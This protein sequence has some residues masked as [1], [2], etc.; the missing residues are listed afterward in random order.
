MS[1]L[2][3]R[4][5]GP[6][7]INAVQINQN[8]L[9]FCVPVLMGKGKVQQTVIWVDGFSAKKVDASGSKGFGG[10]LSNQY[11]YSADVLAA[12]CDGATGVVGIGDV[13]SGQSWLSNTN[14]SE[15]YTIGT[16]SPVY[17]PVNASSMT[18]DHG[19]AR[20]DSLSATYDDL[21]APVPTV[22]STSNV[23]PFQRVPYGTTL[24]TGEYS[25]DPAT[26]AYHF[27][28]S[29]HG[30][31]VTL[32]YTFALGTLTQ[33]V[34]A[35]IS[36]G[37]GLSVAVGGTV[38]FAADVSVV[39]E[40]TGS[41]DG[42]PL[43][44]VSGTP[45]AAG[46]YSVSGSAPATYH[47]ASGDIGQEVRITYKLDNSAALPAGTQTS[48][49]FA[50]IEG[51]PRQ[52]PWALLLTNYPG[53]A[54]GYDGVALV[55]YAPM[56]LGYGAQIQ[57]NTFEVITADAWG[58]S[59]VDCNPVQCILQVLSNPV[60][61]LGNGAVPFPVSAI[62]NGEFGT[63]GSGNAGNGGNGATAYV[64]PVGGP[65]HAITEQTATAWFAA[66]NFF[67]SPVID[68]QDTAASLLGRWLEAGMC[69]AF[70][71]EGLM[72]LVPYGD[73]SAAGNGATWT[74]PTAFEADLDDTCFVTKGTDDPVKISSSPWTEGY[75]TVQI[76]WNNRAA[77]YAPEVTP[78][79]D[80]AAI[81]RYGSRIE[82]PVTFDFITTLAAAR[83]SGSMRVKRN[84][85]NRNTYTFT[86]PY[87]FGFLEPMSIVSLT[88]A[89]AWSALDDNPLALTKQP[90]RITKMVDNPDGSY[91]VTAEDF[92]FGANQP[93]NNNK[94]TGGGNPPP[95]QYAD[96]GDTEAAILVVTPQLAGIYQNQLWIGAAGK[97]EDWGGCNVW[98]SLDGDKYAQIG[99]IEA[100]ARLGNLATSLASGSDPDTAHSMV[101][102]LIESSSPLESGTTDDADNDN[103]LCVV[104]G[105]FISYSACALTGPD[106]YTATT[107]IR[108]GRKGSA[109]AAH[110]SAAPFLRLDDA[111]WKYTFDPTWA[112]KTVYFKFQ[113]FNR[114]G[115]SAQDLSGLA[116]NAFLIYTTAPGVVIEFG[117]SQVFP[118]LVRPTASLPMP[119][120]GSRY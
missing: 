9:G 17:T 115:N 97:N 16:G 34:T 109:I 59:I 42:D 56:D 11:T 27:S 86:L 79:A 12:L 48:L 108:R 49:S 8:V 112:G 116:S 103:T 60:W 98:A 63:W 47:F 61:G 90:V 84:V 31:V 28:G 77:Q 55:A 118:G 106:Q 39:Y 3:Q 57:Q 120:P 105:E 30:T 24:S 62:D 29:D 14:T 52:A 76:Q 68:R 93:S 51:K 74:A 71:S 43:T 110:T 80:K 85:Y 99:T 102:Q 119:P 32:S 92:I 10:K 1:M 113:S 5:Q 73:V 22:L 25:I 46:T 81:N 33:Q 67:I 13:W 107:Y 65:A 40:N 114:F 58:G 75:N 82:D 100:R 4:A 70:M 117:G 72:K 21:T 18:G 66:N 20:T 2:F 89:Q 35:L 111:V 94:V 44:R 6:T 69:A 88:T 53:A 41:T 36:S 26:N 104:D 50:L 64:R 87:R 23:V 15:D 38:P 95:N 91:D 37:A 96:P 101:V 83:F 54:L 78:E 7:R 19:V 45:T